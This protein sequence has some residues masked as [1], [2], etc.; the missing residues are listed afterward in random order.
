MKINFSDLNPPMWFYFDDDDPESGRVLIKSL[1]PK[2]GEQLMKECSK[3]MPPEYRGGHRYE[4]PDK[5]DEKKYNRMLWDA[6]IL[7]WEN[8][9]D[10]KDEPIPCTADNKLRLMYE[11]PFFLE[12]ITKNL[13]I[14]DANRDQRMEQVEKNS[15]TT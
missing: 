14:M 7:D 11:A 5:L 2:E 6:V 15:S 3:K 8:L 10:E 4:I 9:V 12:F 13:K 1:S